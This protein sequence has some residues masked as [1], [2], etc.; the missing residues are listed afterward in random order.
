[1]NSR[2]F[3]E[4]FAV[5][6][7][8]CSHI[9]LSYMGKEVEWGDLLRKCSGGG[10]RRKGEDTALCTGLKLSRMWEEVGKEGA[11]KCTRTGEGRGLML[12]RV[13]RRNLVSTNNAG[14][15]AQRQMSFWIS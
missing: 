6:L 10:R 2:K 11:E 5:I 3:R 13:V 14:V 8:A 9:T 1:M 4:N 7:W 15:G 12:A